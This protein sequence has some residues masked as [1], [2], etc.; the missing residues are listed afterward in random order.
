MSREKPTPEALRK[1]LSS[2]QYHV[3]QEK[4]TERPFTGAYAAHSAACLLY[5][6]PSPRD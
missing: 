2:L 3:T 4:G 5:T 6:S 1:R